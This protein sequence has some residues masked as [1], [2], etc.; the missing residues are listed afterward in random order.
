MNTAAAVGVVAF[1]T[2]VGAS[3][4]Y[5]TDRYMTAK[6]DHSFPWPTLF[7][8][9]V[10]SFILGVVVAIV[11]RHGASTTL[12]VAIGT[13]FCGGLTTFSTFSF[14]SL[15]LVTTQS[16]VRSA[17]YIAASVGLGLSAAALGLTLGS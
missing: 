13:G 9:V 6:F 5:V 4:R 10:G 2:G 14:E 1:G 17:L 8:N 12:Q 11:V 15:R 16:S 7:V 3:A